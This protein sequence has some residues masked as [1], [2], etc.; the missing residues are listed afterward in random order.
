M[1]NDDLSVVKLETVSSF[2]RCYHAQQA[3]EKMLKAAFV[4]VYGKLRENSNKLKAEREKQSGIEVPYYVPNCA[5]ELDNVK[6]PGIHDIVDLW[7][8]LR[9]YDGKA[10]GPLDEKQKDFMKKIT[11]CAEEYRYPYFLQQA[12]T[13][14]S[15][16]DVDVNEVIK[17]SEQLCDDLYDYICGKVT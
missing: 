10:F 5:W 17:A 6:F 2:I 14:V 13:L 1:A 8:K 11:K 12:G 7:E 3:M 9:S 4:I 16:P 15:F